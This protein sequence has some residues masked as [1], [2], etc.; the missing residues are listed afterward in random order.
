MAIEAKISIKHPVD[1]NVLAEQN[2]KKLL[3]TDL[4]RIRIVGGNTDDDI[5]DGTILGK[6]QNNSGGCWWLTPATQPSTQRGRWPGIRVGI[7]HLHPETESMKHQ[8]LWEKLY[9]I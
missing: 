6:R 7:K 9:L 2:R 1:F 4:L 8:H 3:Y 5:F